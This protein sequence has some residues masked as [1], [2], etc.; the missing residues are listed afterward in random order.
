MNLFK[1][2][3]TPICFFVSSVIFAQ[4]HQA[5]KHSPSRASLYSALLPGLGQAYNF[6]HSKSFFT[7]AKIPI[8]YAMGGALT[9]FSLTN[10]NEYENYRDV[11]NARQ[12][13]G[14][15]IPDDD[16]F[17]QL[18][19]DQLR[20]RKDVFRRQRDYNIIFIGVVYAINIIDANV[21][22][23]LMEFNVNPNIS[24]SISPTL[25][26]TYNDKNFTAGVS[27]NFRLNHKPY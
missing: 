27:L 14:N 18:T 4:N 11:I 17:P 24:G 20:S 1:L 19:E 2:L 25:L 3:F 26:P 12:E 21:D 16:T 23:H 7:L 13:N 15:I 10:H 6:S 9:Y 5:I 8:L 22:A